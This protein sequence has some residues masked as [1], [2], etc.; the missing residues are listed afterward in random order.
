MDS[1]ELVS[2]QSP[3]SDQI[4]CY[5]VDCSSHASR[6]DVSSFQQSDEL[7]QHGVSASHLL[8]TPCL[9]SHRG[10]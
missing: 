8:R 1:V 2:M 9:D 3:Q 5:D 6:S 4:C 7:F 10:L